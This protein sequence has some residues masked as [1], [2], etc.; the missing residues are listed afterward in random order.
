LGYIRSVKNFA[1]SEVDVTSIDLHKVNFEDAVNVFHK[2]VNETRMHHISVQVRLVTGKGI[3]HQ[4]YCQLAR[5]YD[6]EYY[7]EGYGCLIV[8]FE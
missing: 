1:A 2:L 4:A 6:L 8:T 3:I 5:E 7:K